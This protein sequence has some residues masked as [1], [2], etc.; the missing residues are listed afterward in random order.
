MM[1]LTELSVSFS[2]L[3]EHEYPHLLRQPLA[4]VCVPGQ[5]SSVC[6][7]LDIFA[8][9]MVGFLYLR[10]NATFFAVGKVAVVASGG[11]T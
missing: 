2:S 5:R 8:G 3:L 6:N 10:G 7:V 11:V 4:S 1:I 9:K